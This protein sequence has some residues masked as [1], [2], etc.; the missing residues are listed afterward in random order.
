[1]IVL[2]LTEE[3]ATILKALVTSKKEQL[4]NSPLLLL[5]LHSGIAAGALRA[6]EVL[7]ELL[8]ILA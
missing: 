8:E 5:Q 2:E 4:R 7:D 3:Q 1:M 6:V